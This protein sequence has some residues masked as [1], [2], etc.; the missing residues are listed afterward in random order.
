MVTMVDLKRDMLSEMSKTSTIWFHL[1]MESNKQNKWKNKQNQTDR[2]R[3]QTGGCQREK[4]VGVRQ[5]GSRGSRDTDF[6]LYS[7]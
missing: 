4:G 1:H 7:K 3:E 2:Y 5:N 6:Q